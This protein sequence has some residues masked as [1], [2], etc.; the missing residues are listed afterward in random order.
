MNIS[1]GPLWSIRWTIS[2]L[3]TKVQNQNLKIEKL[4][5]KALQLLLHL[6]HN[7]QSPRKIDDVI[8]KVIE[9]N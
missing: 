7:C 5:I 1:E 8:T 2:E 9:L 6:T 3:P 4:N